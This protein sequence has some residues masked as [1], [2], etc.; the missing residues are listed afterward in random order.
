MR[1][2]LSS[3]SKVCQAAT[4]WRREGGGIA[5]VRIFNANGGTWYMVGHGLV[6]L[7]CAAI[8]SRVTASHPNS[9]VKLDRARVVLRWGTTRE[10]RVLHIFYF[11]LIYLD[12]FGPHVVEIW[13]LGPCYKV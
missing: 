12:L 8:S 1:H 2:A 11:G 3:D 4:G 13:A 5:E 6:R 10:G 7:P 9:A